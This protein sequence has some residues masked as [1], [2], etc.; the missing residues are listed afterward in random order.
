MARFVAI[1]SGREQVWKDGAGLIQETEKDGVF[2]F[3]TYVSVSV[4]QA[5]LVPSYTGCV[6]LRAGGH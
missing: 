2:K 4:K 3:M 5:P 1:S 6:M